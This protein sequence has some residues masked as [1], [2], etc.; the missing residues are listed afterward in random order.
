MSAVTKFWMFGGALALL[1]CS[2]TPDV[3]PS[4]FARCWKFRAIANGQYRTD[5]VAV[6]YPG[7]G[8]IAYNENCPDL[9]LVMNFAGV[10]PPAGFEGFDEAIRNRTRLIAFAGTA[11]VRVDRQI[12]PRRLG[13]VVQRL[14]KAEILPSPQA[15]RLIAKMK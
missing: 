15:D 9:R 1:G 14:D 5:F 11:V 13:V 3:T 7:S 8:M 4:D 10:A 6:I 12:S 2:K